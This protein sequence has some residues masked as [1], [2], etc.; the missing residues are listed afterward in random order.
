MSHWL[1]FSIFAKIIN[2]KSKYKL[3][4]GNKV[5]NLEN[6][7]AINLRDKNIDGGS[8]HN[9]GVGLNWYVNKNVR[10]SANYIHSNMIPAASRVVEGR[11][12]HHRKLHILAGRVQVVF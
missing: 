3:E 1:T 6:Q 8:A 11:Y 10:V 7:A 4:H 5:R 9:A 12:E 2:N